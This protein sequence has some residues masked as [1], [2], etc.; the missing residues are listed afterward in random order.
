MLSNLSK[1][2]TEGGCA[3]PFGHQTKSGTYN[4]ECLETQLPPTSHKNLFVS[5]SEILASGNE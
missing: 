1:V 2:T 5:F 4:I 3:D